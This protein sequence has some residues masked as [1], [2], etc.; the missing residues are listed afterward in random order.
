MMPETSRD[1]PDTI[2]EST[3]S[4]LSATRAY[5]EAFKGD[6]VAA[7]KSGTIP[8]VQFLYMQDRVEKFLS[9]INLYESIFVNIRDAYS[10]AS[11]STS[12][13]V[14]AASASSSS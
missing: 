6:I 9:Q 7:F 13:R 11:A 8:E 12:R 3:L 5:A 1:D 10:M 14:P 4:H 2:I